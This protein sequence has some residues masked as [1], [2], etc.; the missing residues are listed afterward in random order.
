MHTTFFFQILSEWEEPTVVGENT[1]IL[2]TDADF[3]YPTGI[4]SSGIKIKPCANTKTTRQLNNSERLTEL[5]YIYTCIR[6]LALAKK[7]M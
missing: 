4:K 7:L 5:A 3:P 1:L 2:R 6:A